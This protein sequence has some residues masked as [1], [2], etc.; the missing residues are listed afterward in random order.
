MSNSNSDKFK[1]STFR[2]SAANDL[3]NVS[4]RNRE[5]SGTSSRG[6]GGSNISRISTMRNPN[7]NFSIF[8]K[9]EEAKRFVKPEVNYSK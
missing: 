5:K 7:P 9:N 6:I 4:N 3:F 2:S 1:L 8:N